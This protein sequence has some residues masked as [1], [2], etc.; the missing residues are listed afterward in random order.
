MYSLMGCKYNK[1]RMTMTMSNRVG[2]APPIFMPVW[3]GW[4]HDRPEIK[5]RKEK[6]NKGKGQKFI[7]P[8]V[9]RLKVK[10]PKISKGQNLRRPKFPK[11]QIL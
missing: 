1:P 5:G 11:Y 7:R 8:K 2:P 6:A 10:G 4:E 9:K 3:F